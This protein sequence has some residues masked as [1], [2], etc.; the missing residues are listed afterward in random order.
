MADNLNPVEGYSKL[1]KNCTLLKAFGEHGREGIVSL[2]IITSRNFIP[3]TTGVHPESSLIIYDSPVR[4]DLYGSFPLGEGWDRNQYHG[5]SVLTVRDCEEG[6]KACYACLL[7]QIAAVRDGLQGEGLGHSMLW[8][9][10]E[11]EVLTY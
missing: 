1:S 8:S 7:N 5:G 4:D 3:Q 2:C 9:I 10:G 11:N 6:R